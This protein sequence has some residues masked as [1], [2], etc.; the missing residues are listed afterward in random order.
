MN[1]ALSTVEEKVVDLM[2]QLPPL[3]VQGSRL[4][5]FWLPGIAVGAMATAHRWSKPW[6]V[7][8]PTRSCDV[9]STR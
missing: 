8:L 5:N 3:V 4:S 7:W 6:N 2:R 9:R 1:S